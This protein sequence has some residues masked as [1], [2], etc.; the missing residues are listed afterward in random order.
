MK[1]NAKG[2]MRATSIASK[3]VPTT[4]PNT[5]EFMISLRAVLSTHIHLHRVDRESLQRVIGG[6]PDDCDMMP[7]SYREQCDPPLW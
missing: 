3:T 6:F 2:S 4:T 7:V 5:S 1:G